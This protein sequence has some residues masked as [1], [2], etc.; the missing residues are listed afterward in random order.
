M[1]LT[2]SRG[3]FSN[4]KRRTLRDLAGA[5]HHLV[6]RLSVFLLIF[7]LSVFAATAFFSVFLWSINF[8]V[9]HGVSAFVQ[10]LELFFG[11]IA[12]LVFCYQLA[13][14]VPRLGINVGKIVSM[15]L[16]FAVPVFAASFTSFSSAPPVSPPRFCLA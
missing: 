11:L 16:V 3:I 1:L 7:C 15:M 2:V 4:M 12:F 13:V 9:Q 8:S 14:K 5:E 6:V 10:G